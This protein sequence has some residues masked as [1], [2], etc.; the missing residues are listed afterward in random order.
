LAA[1]SFAQ[2]ERLRSQTVIAVSGPVRLRGEETVNPKLETGTVELAAHDIEILSEAEGLPF[3]NEDEL[4]VREE[5]RLKYRFLDIRPP[6]D[7]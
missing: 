4:G 3:P 6:E 2:A 5:L 1:G 7:A